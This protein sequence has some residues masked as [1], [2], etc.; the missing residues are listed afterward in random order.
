M[1]F[2]I[3]G[4][5]LMASDSIFGQPKT[6]KGISHNAKNQLPASNAFN[7]TLLGGRGVGKTSL[8]ATIYGEF[9][10][11]LSS[12][13][14]LQITLNGKNILHD[15]LTELH[16]ALDDEI[17][18]GIMSGDMD[19]KSYEFELG[20][21]LRPPELK[22]IF[23]DYPG[24]W[25]KDDH[26]D[27]VRN[28]LR[29]SSVILWVIDTA[30]LLVKGDKDQSY[31]VQINQ[32]VHIKSVFTTAL[33]DDI[34]DQAKKLVLF[35]PIKCESWMQTAD[36]AMEVCRCIEREYNS[37]IRAIKSAD[38]QAERFAVAITPVFTLGGV[39]FDRL[40]IEANNQPR[41]VFKR[42]S[43]Q[44]S[45]A[46]QYGE[47]ILAYS[48]NFILNNLHG[49]GLKDD[50]QREIKKFAEIRLSDNNKGFKIIHGDL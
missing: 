11:R 15:K 31:S 30:A 13:C 7:I 20:L 34:P 29:S 1:I 5:L 4:L 32:V 43:G 46:P 25:L 19:K 50:L 28:F 12:D 39:L 3:I 42:R 24:G 49:S 35:V 16:S 9:E 14:G 45:Y 21:S 26:N 6:T 18:H 44:H 36:S 41:F 33:T 8:L 47:Q 48:F 38:P 37:V 23:N 2:A 10:K 27:E 40:E 22:L 17:V